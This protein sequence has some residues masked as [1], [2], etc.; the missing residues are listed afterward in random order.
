M[1]LF[2]RDYRY[3]VDR[4]KSVDVLRNFLSK[5]DVK[6]EQERRWLAEIGAHCVLS[7][8]AFL[9]WSVQAP[10]APPLYHAS[11]V[12]P[13][14]PSGQ[15]SSPSFHPH[16]QLHLRFRIFVLVHHYSRYHIPIYTTN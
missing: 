5:K 7:D 1:V 3:R 4:E 16:D 11:Y 10:Q 9:G 12:Y 8:A 13:S 2:D 15:S 6:L 14:Q